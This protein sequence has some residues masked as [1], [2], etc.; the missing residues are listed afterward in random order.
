V[1]ELDDGWRA[2]DDAIAQLLSPMSLRMWRD[3][4]DGGEEGIDWGDASSSERPPA[5]KH[6]C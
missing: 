4:L 5:T 6:Y 3:R 1:V 2:R